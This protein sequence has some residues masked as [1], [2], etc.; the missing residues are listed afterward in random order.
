M[1]SAM[2]ELPSLPRR[3]RRKVEPASGRVLA[4]LVDPLR[5]V[6]TES[7]AYHVRELDEQ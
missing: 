2:P 6:E 5:C 3:R 4:S 1:K 7:S